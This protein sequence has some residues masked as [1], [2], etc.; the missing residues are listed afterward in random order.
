MEYKFNA[1]IKA[2]NG[3]IVPCIIFF[4]GET[5]ANI[6]VFGSLFEKPSFQFKLSKY[7]FIR[8]YDHCMQY[9]DSIKMTGPMVL[10][11]RLSKESIIKT[12]EKKYNWM[13]RET[14]EMIASDIYQSQDVKI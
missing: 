3:A 1:E 11:P 12:L 7:E 10:T 9:L 6:R 13:S 14:I 2:D 5:P 8:A 4:E